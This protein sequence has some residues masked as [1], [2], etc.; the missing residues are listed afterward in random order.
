M[1][2][3]KSSAK[4]HGRTRRVG[5]ISRSVSRP[6]DV[7][8]LQRQLLEE[9]P[10]GY[11]LLMG[12]PRMR[13][14]IKSPAFHQWY[15]SR[16][17]FDK[18]SD[19]GFKK[20]TLPNTIRAFEI[21]SKLPAPSRDTINDWE[22]D[23]VNR[24][25]M[26]GSFR[27]DGKGE[28][29]HELPKKGVVRLTTKSGYGIDLNP[30]LEI[31][32]SKSFRDKFDIESNEVIFADFNDYYDSLNTTNRK[33][34]DKKI[35]SLNDDEFVNWFDKH[36]G[37]IRFMDIMLDDEKVRSYFD[38]TQDLKFANTPEF[39]RKF[40]LDNFAI[41][42]NLEEYIESLPT[43]SQNVILDK[44]ENLS[45]DKFADWISDYADNK[46][47]AFLDALLDENGV[48]SFLDQKKRG[49]SGL[50][51]A[52]R[53]NKDGS[54][55]KGS[56]A[57]DIAVSN[58]KKLR[59]METQEY[60][61]QFSTYELER[62]R[63]AIAGTRKADDPKTGE[64]EVGGL[65][66]HK[67]N[68]TDGQTIKPKIDDLR[69]LLSVVDREVFNR[70]IFNNTDNNWKTLTD[71][72]GKKAKYRRLTRYMIDEDGMSDKMMKNLGLD[73]LTLGQMEAY[74]KARDDEWDKPQPRATITVIRGYDK[75]SGK[76]TRFHEVFSNH[77]KTL[78]PRKAKKVAPHTPKKKIREKAITVVQV[79]VPK[80]LDKLVEVDTGGFSFDDL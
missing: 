10:D 40:G 26:I 48:E 51:I 64:V 33:K 76:T 8:G 54:Y 14:I 2:I 59:R 27:F 7:L 49:D 63:Q 46:K 78:R 70:K 32:N 34:L 56:F 17:P 9:D 50:K 11:E 22:N 62:M 74:I 1:S 16:R 47:V 53:R 35:E 5:N 77:L 37:N 30:M 42:P 28:Y 21:D 23:K 72:D 39:G 43:K 25:D 29:L 41:Y 13:A 66:Y 44:Y 57:Y 68:K 61:D 80:N 55:P 20:L 67:K 24:V 18:P 73:K 15:H 4:K 3:R 58:A 12:N 38:V 75:K 19:G 60:L 31:A 69:K 79:K 36:H 65:L 71:P 45:N 6:T 52:G